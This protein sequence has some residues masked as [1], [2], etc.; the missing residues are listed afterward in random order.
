MRNYNYSQHFS[1]IKPHHI[2]IAALAWWKRKQIPVIKEFFLTP[3]EKADLA[4]S[5]EINRMPVNVGNLTHDKSK[6]PLFAKQIHAATDGPGTYED[7]ISAVFDQMTTND[8]VVMLVKAY[9]IRT[10]SAFMVSDGA[11]PLPQQLR[12]ELTPSD[13]PAIFDKLTQ[14]GF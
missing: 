13:Y 1:G 4:A 14:A 10:T 11:K 12:S 5:K 3:E 9:G 8:D 7:D 2:I 6:Y